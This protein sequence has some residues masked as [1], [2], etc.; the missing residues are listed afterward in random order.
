MIKKESISPD[1]AQSFRF[2]SWEGSLARLHLYQSKGDAVEMRGMGEEW[3][4]HPEIEL[5]L[6]TE[7]KGIR[8]VGDNIS[9]FKAPELVLLGP[10]LP[11]H[12][13]TDD[14]SGYCIQFS[15][16]PTSPLASLHESID[17]KTTISKASRGLVF[18]KQ[19]V[20]EVENMM[21]QGIDCNSIERLSVLLK[22]LSRINRAN[23]KVLSETTPQGLSHNRSEAVRKAV[24]FILKNVTDE[25]LELKDVLEHI[26]MS[27]ATFSRHFQ[28]IL[29]Q[30]YTKFV[31][32]IRLET[33]RNFLAS[34]DKPITEVAY[35]SGFSSIS[36]F[37]TLFKKRWD[38]TPR[39]FRNHVKIDKA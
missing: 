9:S 35:A 33:A 4:Y 19:C 26:S 16:D 14:S 36:H 1:P 27:R 24:R 39:A 21:K 22:I 15:L 29:G 20:K 11:H 38:M 6:F 28:L 2:F 10:N 37:N 5:T 3:H 34:T 31:Q 18:S 13:T 7:G 23:T 32:S 17:L 8:Y 30:P 25:S 12:W